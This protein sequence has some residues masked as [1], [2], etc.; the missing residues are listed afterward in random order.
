MD[1]KKDTPTSWVMK[2]ESVTWSVRN[3]EAIIQVQRPACHAQPEAQ[4]R[5]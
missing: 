2:V 3:P 1:E 4:R 5:R